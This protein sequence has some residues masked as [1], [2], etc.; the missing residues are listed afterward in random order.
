[1]DDFL[2]VAKFSLLDFKGDF[3]IHFLTKIDLSPGYNQ[4]FAYRESN[5]DIKEVQGSL[6]FAC[7]PSYAL[8]QEKLSKNTWNHIAITGDLDLETTVISIYLNGIKAT[9]KEDT[10]AENYPSY[11]R[12]FTQNLFI[13]SLDPSSSFLKGDLEQFS[14]LKTQLSEQE[15]IDIHKY[16]APRFL[17]S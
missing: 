7:G 13:G 1:M 4:R 10:F 3:T 6:Q 12:K 2:Q 15:I 5:L 9:M 17:D 16:N 14:I 11:E 8:T